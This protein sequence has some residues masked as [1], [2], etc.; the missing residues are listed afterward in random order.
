[1][2]LRA[3]GP[4]ELPALGQIRVIECVPGDDCLLG[5]ATEAVDVGGQLVDLGLAVNGVLA[6]GLRARRGKRHPTGAHLEVHRG[7]ADPDEARS[8]TTALSV[9]TVAA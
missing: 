4:V 9:Q 8:L 3:V 7:G 6:L 1:M 5:A 2:A